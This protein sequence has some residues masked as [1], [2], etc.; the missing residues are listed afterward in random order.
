M[1][2]WISNYMCSTYEKSQNLSLFVNEHT[3][4]LKR[5]SKSDALIPTHACICVTVNEKFPIRKLIFL[6]YFILRI[7]FMIWWIFVYLFEVKLFKCHGIKIGKNSRQVHFHMFKYILALTKCYKFSFL[8]L[9]LI[10][11]HPLRCCNYICSY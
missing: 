11:F 6:I 3:S 1:F 4:K 10:F 8:I 9:T 2:V 5:L 7:P